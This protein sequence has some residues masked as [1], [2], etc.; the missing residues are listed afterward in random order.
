M[1]DRWDSADWQDSIGRNTPDIVGQEL[2][3]HQLLE[4]EESLKDKTITTSE[5]SRIMRSGRGMEFKK[6][7][8]EMKR[9]GRVVADPPPPTYDEVVKANSGKRVWKRSEIQQLTLDEWRELRQMGE[10]GMNSNASN[11]GR[12]FEDIDGSDLLSYQIGNSENSIPLDLKGVVNKVVR[13]TKENL[14]TWWSQRHA[15]E[16]VKK[17]NDAT[18]DLLRK[19][20]VP[21]PE[22]NQ[23]GET[24]INGVKQP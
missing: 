9:Q 17:K 18:L 3:M 21:K 14:D 10:L 2:K 1:E 11:E 24:Y 22:D 23:I 4:G 19:N 5:A 13:D 6:V 16:A 15:Y 7:I 8:E 20:Y 12:I